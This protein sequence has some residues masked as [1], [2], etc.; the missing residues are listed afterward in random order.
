M[1]EM[2]LQRL[3]ALAALLIALCVILCGCRKSGVSPEEITP[4][5]PNVPANTVSR[6]TEQT[7]PV[8]A[9]PETE[10]P[11]ESTA[12]TEAEPQSSETE[13]TEA[14]EAETAEPDEAEPEQQT[15]TVKEL[16]TMAMDYLK[17]LN[18]D[19]VHAKMVIILSYG[20]D[21]IFSVKSEYYVDGSER[22]YIDDTTKTMIKDGKVTVVDYDRGIWFSYDDDGE[23]G[24]NF[25]F[26]TGDYS[27]VSTG[28]DEDGVYTETYDVAGG[29][30]STWYFDEGNLR[31]A[32][33]NINEG[34]YTLYSFE[35]IEEST[36]G[37][38]FSVPEDF[39]EEEY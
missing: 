14:A 10:S 26:E 19:K 32:D 31:V 1:K 29:I 9:P 2:V 39:A 37:M 20:S 17:L 11:P 8:T 21:D 3:S 5:D 13:P 30:T 35:V 15:E 7:E 38:D 25:G 23:Y 27:L 6:A 4:A 16:D 12:P 36:E 18:S 28:Y 24:I 33:R 22:I 34:N